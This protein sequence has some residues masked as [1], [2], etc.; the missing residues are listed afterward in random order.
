MW[1]SLAFI[2]ALIVFSIYAAFIGAERAQT[3]FNSLPLQIFWLVLLLA[4][5]AS[6]IIHRPLLKK[7]S[8]LLIHVGCLLIL[9]G[10]IVAS[11]TGHGIL[12]RVLGINKIRAGKM[13]IHEGK[14]SNLV[15]NKEHHLVKLPFDLRLDDF[16]IEYYKQ[17]FDS[18]L[19]MGNR[20]SIRDFISDLKVI[21]NGKVVAAKSI[22]VNKPLCYG[23]YCFYQSS[24]DHEKE[25]FTILSVKSNSGIGLVFSGYI[26]LMIGVVWRLWFRAIPKLRANN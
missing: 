24:Y 11:E 4:F 3:F 23:G 8:L 17:Q 22:E 21:D 16:R 2:A 20:H 18:D 13:I 12:G 1:L 7:K 25:S 6:L 14:C 15:V 19:T 5:I 26:F 9:L 10:S